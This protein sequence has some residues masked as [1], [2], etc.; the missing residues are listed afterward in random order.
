MN[1]VVFCRLR[2]DGV[3]VEIDE[4]NRITNFKLNEELGRDQNVSSSTND[5][6]AQDV[7]NVN[8]TLGSTVGNDEGSDEE[9]IDDNERNAIL[10]TKAG[11]RCV[12]DV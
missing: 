8:S 11:K 7:G 4:M 6:R 5:Y 9:M 12:M 2:E 1:L 10:E 3:M